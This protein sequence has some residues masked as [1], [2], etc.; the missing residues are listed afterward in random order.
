MRRYTKEEGAYECF[1]EFLVRMGRGCRVRVLGEGTWDE[2]Q[3][4]AIMPRWD[5]LDA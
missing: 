1:I 5:P 2:V 3:E 4:G